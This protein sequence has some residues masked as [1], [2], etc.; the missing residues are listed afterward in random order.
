MLESHSVY[1]P[2]HHRTSTYDFQ[3]QLHACHSVNGQIVDMRRF[4]EV[5]VM[6]QSLH[7]TQTN[8]FTTKMYA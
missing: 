1:P 7:L 2:K 4:S 3:L 8:N 6:R 5:V